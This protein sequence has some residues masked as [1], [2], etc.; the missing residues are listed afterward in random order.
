MTERPESDDVAVSSPPVG[1]LAFVL[2]IYFITDL[3][4]MGIRQNATGGAGIA[5]VVMS[6]FASQ[7]ILL[8]LWLGLG[9]ARLAV[10]L[11]LVLLWCGWYAILI[12]LP[13]EAMTVSSLAGSGL[14]LLIAAAPYGLLKI[15]G[16]RIVRLLGAPHR[17]A[18]EE[19]PL[20]SDLFKLTCRDE[21]ALPASPWAHVRYG[22]RV[23]F[24][25]KHL[26]AWMLLA[27]VV[28]TLARLTGMEVEDAVWLTIPVAI[29]TGLGLA[30]MW[31]VLG[32]T[33]VGARL[34]APY[35][36]AGLITLFMAVLAG[37]PDLREMVGYAF[38]AMAI[39]ISIVAAVLGLFR[40]AGYR[41]RR[42]SPAAFSMGDFESAGPMAAS[43]W[44]A[45]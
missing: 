34:L 36:L 26:F 7:A 27:S 12:S 28:A 30:T 29:L 17:R 14:F 20:S 11:P 43:P 4:A 3:L 38:G 13:F 2:V 33:T 15:L 24:S 22:A 1:Q 35:S 23:Q 18:P 21:P 37:G 32:G 19:W 8:A 10:R 44:D 42:P 5:I 45:E 25:M 41:V 39:T 16:F 31:A 40:S 9:N 6:L